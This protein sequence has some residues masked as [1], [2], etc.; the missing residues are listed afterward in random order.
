MLTGEQS[1]AIAEAMDLPPDDA[2]A[3]TIV[4]D[5]SGFVEALFEALDMKDVPEDALP[6][7]LEAL[8]S[9][10]PPPANEE[11]KKARA[12]RD[13]KKAEV[14]ARRKKIIEKHGALKPWMPGWHPAKAGSAKKGVK[15]GEEDEAVT[16]SEFDGLSESVQ[17][18][19][20]D[21]LRVQI[22]TKID[23]A[24]L[25]EGLAK[26]A[27]SRFD[28]ALEDRGLIRLAEVDNFITEL[29]AGLGR[30]QNSGGNLTDAASGD[31]PSGIF[32]EWSS[33]DKA[34]AA[35]EGLMANEPH[36]LLADG[37][38]KVD[39][40]AGIRQAYGIISG[41][42]FCEG[43]SYYRRSL[44]E[45]K[46]RGVWES[47]DMETNEYFQ[48]YVQKYG[49]VAEA[50]NTASFT[51]L[52][53]N[54]MHK[55]MV[56]EYLQQ[57]FLW[58]GLA[59][60]ENV[61]DFKAWRFLRLG[62][63]ADLSVVAE[64]A[65]YL[66]DL[67]TP[68]EEEITFAIQKRGGISIITWEMVINDEMQKI[69]TFPGK[70]ARASNRTLNKHVIGIMTGNATYDVDSV[71][72]FHAASHVNLDSTAYSYDKIKTLR[73]DMDLHKD[74]DDKE[75]RRVKA[76]HL[77]AGA[78]MY[79]AVYSDLFTDG[80]PTLSVDRT[81]AAAQPMDSPNRPNILRSKYGLDLQNLPEADGTNYVYLT[82]DP[83]EVDMIVVGFL[84]GN[85]LPQLFVQ[86]L[87]RVGSFFDEDEITYKIRHIYEADLLDYRPF[88][89]VGA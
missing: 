60:A 16:R 37:K 3:A 13:E 46:R 50:M 45:R 44:A 40:F 33:G 72:L 71:A 82:G 69:R 87:D 83:S 20:Q 26:F 29:K 55:A 61:T 68:T 15:E 54:L 62:E 88:A 51:A 74:P 43:R 9:E 7:V 76:R 39:S 25:P 49:N 77:W 34:A 10:E 27:I 63:F 1:E 47:L 23:E 73:K 17:G 89:R 11:E 52:L 6:F 81:A 53:S 2:D 57:D 42:L 56:K 38:T 31:T 80:Q 5:H 84:N 28:S 24:K 30:S 85:Q 59:R 18:V 75:A 78:D 14:E 79:D 64:G 12:K 65:A 4:K 70:M 22:K 48:D 32:V 67:G 35:F 66:D 19:L 8:A 58:K 41:D 86:D 21:N 36:G